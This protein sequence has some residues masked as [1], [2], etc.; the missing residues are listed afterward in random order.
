MRAPIL[1]LNDMDDGGRVLKVV[2]FGAAVL[3]VTASESGAASHLR[4][5]ARLAVEHLGS[6]PGSYAA[7]VNTT[8]HPGDQRGRLYFGRAHMWDW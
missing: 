1:T 2:A 7:P 5:A 3:A 6:K 4:L 8:G